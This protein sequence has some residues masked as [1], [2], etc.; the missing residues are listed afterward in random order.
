MVRQRA[1]EIARINGRKEH[2]EED[3]RQANFEV[4]G[5]NQGASDD[6]ENEMV[7]SGH[8]MLAYDPGHHTENIQSGGFDNVGEELISEGMD[9]AV[10]DQMLAASQPEEEEGE[11]A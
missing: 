1:E 7:F 9:E 4:H 2:N 3:W 11:D 5:H 10:H 8:D 6:Q